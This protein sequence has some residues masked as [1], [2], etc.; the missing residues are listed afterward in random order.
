MHHNLTI[1]VNYQ[2]HKHKPMKMDLYMNV[3]GDGA[4]RDLR[5]IQEYRQN[6][7]RYRDTTSAGLVHESHMPVNVST[8]LAIISISMLVL[9][10]WAIVYNQVC[11]G[12]DEH[13]KYRRYFERCII[14][15]VGMFH[16]VSRRT[17]YLLH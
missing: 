3:V 8:V 2:K 12:G 4:N 11:N 14:K 6:S 15:K 1:Q 10:L 5:G 13:K 9:V 16:S 17:E 7:S